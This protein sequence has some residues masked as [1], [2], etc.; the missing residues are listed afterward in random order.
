MTIPF[1]AFSSNAV[2]EVLVPSWVWISGKSLGNAS[3]SPRAGA[4]SAA[5][6]PFFAFAVLGA[7][8]ALLAAVATT[9]ATFEDEEGAAASSFF[10]GGS[11]SAVVVVV[12][13]V[14][15]A[16]TLAFFGAGF[17]GSAD[18]RFLVGAATAAG[19]G[20]GAASFFATLRPLLR[21]TG[22]DIA[23]CANFFLY[24]WD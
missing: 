12:A 17:F 8:F 21:R 7:G 2:K 3:P 23:K 22:S 19:A 24:A 9:V 5:C 14:A 18:E 15:A 13:V 11:A 4:P 16:F 1:W 6:S 10:A 20:G